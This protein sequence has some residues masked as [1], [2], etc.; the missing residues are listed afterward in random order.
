MSERRKAEGSQGGPG[1]L[2]GGST[3]RPMALILDQ[4]VEG[5][6]AASAP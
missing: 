5:F 4:A 6:A 1:S 2:S 3:A